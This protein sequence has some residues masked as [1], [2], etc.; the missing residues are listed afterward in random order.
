M[1]AFLPFQ[2]SNKMLNIELRNQIRSHALENKDAECCGLVLE[3][4]NSK[5]TYK[6]KNISSNSGEHFELSP[7]DYL[8][9]WNGG[10]NKIIGFYHSQKSAKPSTLDVIVRRNHK[11]PSY[12]YSLDVDDFIEVTDEHLK[13]GD[14]LGKD[15]ELGKQD[16]FTLIRDFY[17]KEYGI[18]IRDYL[19]DDEI[20]NKNKNMADNIYLME[21]FTKVDIKDIIEGDVI[22]FKFNHFGIY[23]TGDLLL[24]HARNRYSGIERLGICWR[25]KILNCYRYVK[26][27]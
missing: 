18:S 26:I 14:Y 23:I 7:L 19:R 12:I 21:N 22:E 5:L 2:D 1:E 27:S 4:G 16:C 20:L 9:A 3:S 13:Y 24:H 25:E 10:Q 6:C 17:Q 11:I 15:F 8:R